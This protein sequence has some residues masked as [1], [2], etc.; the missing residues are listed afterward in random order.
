[1]SNRP[2]PSLWLRNPG[3]SAVI[4]ASHA[5]DD[6]H[7]WDAA[8]SFDSTLHVHENVLQT[9]DTLHVCV[10]VREKCCARKVLVGCLNRLE[11]RVNAVVAHT[12]S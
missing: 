3:N 12:I 8:T 1:M 9:V 11:A 5:W 4:A 2:T 7:A 6:A 10:C